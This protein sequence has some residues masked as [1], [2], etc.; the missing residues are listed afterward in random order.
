VAE[1]KPPEVSF[2]SWVEQ[3]IQRAVQRGEF[4]DLP[5]AGQPIP[6]DE[7]PWIRKYLEREQLPADALLPPALALRKQVER[8]PEQVA[9]YHSEDQVREAAR[10][11]N[12]LIAE[13]YRQPSGPALP[14]RLVDADAL[15]AQ[16]RSRQSD[17]NA[18]AEQGQRPPGARPNVGNSRETATKPAK[19]KGRWRPFRGE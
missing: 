8:L 14:V 2:P 10:Q 7:R 19:R 6:Q 9:R 13:Y 18:D 16:W 17:L 1:R 12:R 11:M 15:V 4:A 3:Q 5:G